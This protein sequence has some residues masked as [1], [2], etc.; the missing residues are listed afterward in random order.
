[1]NIGV[2]PQAPD[3]LGL[4]GGLEDDIAVRLDAW[5]PEAVLLYDRLLLAQQLFHLCCKTRARVSGRRANQ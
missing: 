5:H 4:L 1:M 3:G 2:V